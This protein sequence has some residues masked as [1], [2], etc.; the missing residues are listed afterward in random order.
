MSDDLGESDAAAQRRRVERAAQGL[1]A[2]VAA[3]AEESLALLKRWLHGDGA[4]PALRQDNR[5]EG[6]PLTAHLPKGHFPTGHLPKGD[7]R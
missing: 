7:W 5:P 2:V 6:H 1:R 4:A 3:H